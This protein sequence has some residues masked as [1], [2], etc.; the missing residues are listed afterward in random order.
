M[1]D[2][3]DAVSDVPESIR[4]NF[5]RSDGE[6]T[7]IELLP[8][9]ALSPNQQVQWVRDVRS[10]DVAAMTGV[11]G[12]VLRVGGVPALEAEYESVVKERLPKVVLGVVLGSLLALLIGLRSLFAAVKAVLLNLLSV[13]AA[14]GALV[15]VFQDGHGSKLFRLEGPTGSVYPIVPI[16]SFAI[17]FGLS[18]DYEVFLVARVLEERR[19]G[20]SERSAV[21]EG[22]AR[23]AGLITSAAAIMIAVF[24]AFTLGSFLVVQMLGFTLAGA[25][26][27]DA[28]VV[29]MVVGPALLRLAG[30]WNWWP[31]GL[32]GTTATSEK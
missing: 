15:I 3:A 21:I 2:T 20:L 6:A 8:T 18:M 11:P 12:A 10:S 17:V 14:F 16:L 30:D 7:L 1:S 22:L 27:I 28:T 13:G 4:K 19:R 26:L 25:V 29:R 5:L 24:T 23:T 32:Y 9:A 31:F